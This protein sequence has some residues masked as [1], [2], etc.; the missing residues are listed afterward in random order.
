MEAA[1]PGGTAR[2]E[3]PGLSTAREAFAAMENSHFFLKK[4]NHPD[5][6]FSIPTLKHCNQL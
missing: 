5:N 1:T 6:S 4:T 2:A 3:D